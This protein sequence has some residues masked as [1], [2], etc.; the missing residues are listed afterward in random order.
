MKIIEK[1]RILS[2]ILKAV[3][4]MGLENKNNRLIKADIKTELYGLNGNL[5]S[6]LLVRLIVDV[7]ERVSSE[8][9]KEIVIAD[10]RAMSLKSSP[11]KNIETLTD[12]TFNLL[13]TA[14]E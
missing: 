10:E 11:F 5:D 12:Y 9:G 7:E 8:L 2:L 4:E 13:N 3:Q 14:D 6:L 1:D